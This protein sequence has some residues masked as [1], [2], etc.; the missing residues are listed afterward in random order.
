MNLTKGK[1]KQLVNAAMDNDRVSLT[2]KMPTNWELSRLGSSKLNKKFIP[3][4]PDQ[5][6]VQRVFK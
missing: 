3:L 5:I 6:Y 1:R 4:P 2:K